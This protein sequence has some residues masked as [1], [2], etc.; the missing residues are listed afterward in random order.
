MSTTYRVV[1]HCDAVRSPACHGLVE[2][3]DSTLRIVDRVPLD[4]ERAGWVREYRGDLRTHDVC[5]ACRPAV[6]ATPVATNQEAA[7]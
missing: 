6:E 1:V 2:W 7:S 3:R 5:P 4:A